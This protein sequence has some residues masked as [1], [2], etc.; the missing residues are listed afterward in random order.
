M[1]PDCDNC[2]LKGTQQVHC[3]KPISKVPMAVVGE[4]PGVLEEVKK[5]YFVGQSGKYLRIGFNMLQIPPY[6]VHINNALLCRAPRNLTAKKWRA[7]LECCQQRLIHELQQA[8]VTHILAIGKRAFHALTKYWTVSQPWW[9]APIDSDKLEGV[10][11]ICAPHPAFALRGQ[12]Q[13][14]PIFWTHL[15]RVWK[16]SQGE[17]P[18]RWQTLWYFGRNERQTLAALERISKA[19]GALVGIDIETGGSDPIR[20]PIT[21][22]GVAT[23]QVAVSILWPPERHF[24]QKRDAD[25]AER[26]M[27]RIFKNPKLLKVAHNGVHDILGLESKGYPVRGYEHDTI[28]LHHVVGNTLKHDLGFVAQTEFSCDPWKKIFKVSGDAK[29]LKRFL[30]ASGQELTE[31]NAKDTAIL[32]RLIDPLYVRLEQTHNGHELYNGY[33]ERS[34]IAMELQQKGAKVNQEAVKD[35]AK[36][37]KRRIRYAQNQLR[38]AIGLASKGRGWG[39]KEDIPTD[40]FKLQSPFHLRQLFYDRLGVIPTRWSAKTGAPSTDANILKALCGYSDKLISSIARAML[41]YRKYIKLYRTYIIKLKGVPRIHASAK[42][43]GTKGGRWSYE[44]PNLQN[45]PPLLRDVIEAPRGMWIVEADYSQLELR[46]LAL[47]AG[48]K[49]LLRWYAEGK[50]VHTMNALDLFGPAADPAKAGKSKAKKVRKLAKG[51][52]Y[53][54]VPMHTQA[55]TR[56]GWRTYNQL[57]VGDQILVYDPKTN[58]KRWAP[59]LSFT[60]HDR[61]EV[62]EIK[63]S[64]A[65][66]VQ[67]TPDHK[68]WVKQRKDNGKSRYYEYETRTT[69]EINSESNIVMNA[70]MEPHGQMYNLKGKAGPVWNWNQNHGSIAEAALAASAIEHDGAI[71]CNDR[72]DSHSPMINCR[73]SKMQHTTGQKLQKRR[74]DD[75]AVW[76]PAVSTGYWVMRQNNCVTITGNSNYGGSAQTIWSALVVNFPGLLL[77]D[78]ERLMAVW[79]MVQ[80]E[81]PAWQQKVVKQAHKY[82]YTECPLSG[83]RQYFHGVV[84]PTKCYNYPIQGTGADL[85]DAA[86]VKVHRAFKQ[87]KGTRLLFQVHD[88]LVCETDD[89]V[90][91]CKVLKKY[92]EAKVTLDGNTA[93]FPIDFKLGRNWA[94]KDE[95]T[96]P[97]GCVECETLEDVKELVRAS[98]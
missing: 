36:R 8:G 37:L 90:Y 14:M 40:Q 12:M 71:W 35:H 13:Y 54:C 74:V 60:Y 10:T 69:A 22:L 94:M 49:K 24:V 20:D 76:C 80:P 30:T 78:I 98:R 58:T 88:A 79:A 48:A 55:L 93:K 5:E 75:Q 15:E 56:N 95:K 57:S 46:I 28:L 33:R 70:P 34:R 42:V 68:W 44:K 82:D 32:P 66:K 23:K 39:P 26:L 84:E 96:N 29:G 11:V 1:K 47:L 62:W 53:G 65:F 61:A 45:I 83:R 38:D 86:I 97:N 52:V 63:T 81:I 85:I 31:Y 67:T 19:E 27:R 64:K 73:L 89:P 6:K 9:G 21:A 72:K 91:C 43:W 7:A 2:P 25:K 18:F 51:F 87:R 41:R 4:A 50:D 92:M 3:E 77:S 16:L 17:R 59:I